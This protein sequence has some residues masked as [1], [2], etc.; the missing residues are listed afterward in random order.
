MQPKELPFDEN[1]ESAGQLRPESQEVSRSARQDSLGVGPFSG[2][3]PRG[4]WDAPTEQ[5]KQHG[6]P[7]A[8]TG[9]MS[10][11]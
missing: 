11:P 7:S 6:V 1:R 2:R 5:H 3:P 8:T 9:A 4:S 10:E